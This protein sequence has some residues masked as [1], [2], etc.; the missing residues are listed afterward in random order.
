MVEVRPAGRADMREAIVSTAMALIQEKGADKLSLR[1]IAR[2]IGHSPA[3]L[4][5]YFGSKAE[6]VQAVRGR[7]QERFRQALGRVPVDL[8]VQEYLV[9]LG[10]AYVD[11]ANRHPQEFRLLFTRLR[12][13]IEEDPA[14]QSLAQESYGLLD[15]AIQRAMDEKVLP[16]HSGLGKDEAVYA[17]WSLVHGMAMLQVEYLRDLELDFPAVDEAALRALVD[18]LTRQG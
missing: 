15:D 6:I 7:A 18:G 12:G 9:Q 3:G 11:F 1:E 17:M 16:A 4:Y 13:R 14:E 5:E 8:P 2:T 10:L